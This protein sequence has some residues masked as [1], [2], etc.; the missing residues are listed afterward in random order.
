MKLRLKFGFPQRRAAARDEEGAI[1]V[2]WAVALVSIAGLVA[3]AVDLGNIAQTKQHTVNAAQAAALAAVVDLAPLSQLGATAADATTAEGTAVTEAETYLH[4]NFTALPAAGDAAYG[5]CGTVSSLYYA[6]GETCVGF[7]NTA[8]STK[9]QTAPN[10]IEVSVPVV[11]TSPGQD[12]TVHYTF[13]RVSGLSIQKVSSTAYASLQTAASGYLLPFGVSNTGGG[14]I[15]LKDSSGGGTPCPGFTTGS[16]KFG[17][18]NNPRYSFFTTSSYADPATSN[19]KFIET[20]ADL[21]I[22]HPLSDASSGCVSDWPSAQNPCSGSNGNNNGNGLTANYV[23]PATGQTVNDLAGPLFR[24]GVTTPDGGC[25]LYPRLGH[26]DGFTA[27]SSCSA[28]N[29][30]NPSGPTLGDPNDE[31]QGRTSN[32][33]GT[34]TLNGVPIAEY[35]LNSYDTGGTPGCSTKM[36]SGNSDGAVITSIDSPS[37]A[38]PAWQ[39]YDNCLSN[40]MQSSPPTTP[41][42]AADIIKSPRFGVVPV[43]ADAHGGT[44][45]QILSFAGVY[46][47]LA[48]PKSD[49]SSKVGSLVAWVFPLT[50]ITDSA[51]TVGTGG[52]TGS[53]SGGPLVANLCAYG[54]NC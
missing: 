11:S 44:D 10:A 4:D 38:N 46:L 16:G 7:F 26:P 28:D 5:T 18:I 47:D 35:L 49:N 2:V 52:G 37:A 42:F 39:A 45:Q 29:V 43:L 36:P 50:W 41:I 31:F 17:V 25:T 15:C 30:D 32:C 22:D 21:G 23:N 53:D 48:Y 33:G 20:N 51:S 27:T 40:L 13:G 12:N 34:C 14:L 6:S 1:L 9:N 19:N 8:D 54:K 24:G 3:M